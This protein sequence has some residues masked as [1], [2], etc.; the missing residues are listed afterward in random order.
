MLPNSLFEDI[1][2][3]GVIEDLKFT[4]VEVETPCCQIVF[5]KI[6]GNMGNIED[7]WQISMTRYFFINY[8]IS[9]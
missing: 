7:I 5:L 2:Q 9:V 1:W 3:H 8:Y 6:F 4:F